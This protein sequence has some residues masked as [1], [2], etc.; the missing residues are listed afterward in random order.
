MERRRTRGALIVVRDEAD[1]FGDKIE[2]SG[3][4]GLKIKPLQSEFKP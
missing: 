1:D 4:G 3:G 2:G